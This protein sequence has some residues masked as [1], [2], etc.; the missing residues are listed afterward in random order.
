VIGLSGALWLAVQGA[1]PIDGAPLFPIH[2]GSFNLFAWQFLFIMGVVIG[3][4]RATPHEA[5]LT[6]RPWLAALAG[7]AALYGWGV[8]H[9]HWRPPWSDSL[10]G[11]MVNKPALGCMRLADFASVAYLAALAASRFPAL[12]TWRPFAFLGRHS[13]AIFAAQSVV[14]VTLLEFP[15]LFATPSAN[16]LTS[17]AAIG[18]LFAVAGARG[19]AR[20]LS[21]SRKPAYGRLAEAGQPA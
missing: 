20:R 18:A 19:A 3:H 4:A 7:A 6:L 2:V 8:C 10:F 14:A 17:A 16:F 5:R 11:I 13:I 21:T 15:V 1:P 12:F 9:L